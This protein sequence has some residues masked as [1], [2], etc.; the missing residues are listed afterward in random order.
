MRP[1]S[2][3]SHR[4]AEF[5]LAVRESSL[6]RLR[7]VPVGRE[8]W[9]PDPESLSFADQAQHL[10]DADNWLARKMVDHSL[11]S[12]VGRAGGAQ[13]DSRDDYMRLLA[14]LEGSGRKR[15][16]LIAGLSETELE[17]IIPDDRFGDEAIVWW[18][19]VRGNLDHEIH[20]RGQISAWL[21]PASR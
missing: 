16:E 4:L 18:V 11:T 14:E 5:S 8:N 21:R 10:I 3:E 19:I 6:K 15:A 20:H 7:A 17:Q 9:R 1:E 13:I 2:A 12:F